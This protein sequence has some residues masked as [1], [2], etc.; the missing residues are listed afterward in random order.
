MSRSFKKRNSFLSPF[1]VFSPLEKSGR[2]RRRRRRWSPS[3]GR[4]GESGQP[5]PRSARAA[6]TAVAW[7]AAAARAASAKRLQE[8]TRLRSPPDSPGLPRSP[9]RRPRLRAARPA[10][11]H[12]L[13][14]VRPLLAPSS[15]PPAAAACEGESHAQGEIRLHDNSRTTGN[16]ISAK[17]MA[18][19]SV[20]GFG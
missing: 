13:R 5:A 14:Q 15:V 7:A 12:L 4:V 17:N 10:R 2:R 6:N 16:G 20:N 3:A 19:K 1:L 18:M 11:P 8:E 9:T